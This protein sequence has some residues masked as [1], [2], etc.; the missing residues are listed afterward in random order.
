MNSPNITREGYLTKLGYYLPTWRQRWFVL[1]HGKLLYYTDHTRKSLKGVIHLKSSTA[2]SV[3]QT[4][5]RSYLCITS[6][7]RQFILYAKTDQD[8]IDWEVSIKKHMRPWT[9]DQQ[10]GNL[11]IGDFEILGR[12][13]REETIVE[14]PEPRPN[15]DEVMEKL[16]EAERIQNQHIEEAERVIDELH[17]GPGQ[18]IQD[19]GPIPSL[20]P[21][22]HPP[23]PSNLGVAVPVEP[24]PIEVAPVQRKELQNPSSSSQPIR[25]GNANSMPATRSQNLLSTSPGRLFVPPSVSSSPPHGHGVLTVPTVYSGL[26]LNSPL[27]AHYLQPPPIKSVHPPK[28]I[29]KRVKK[30]GP[31][32]LCPY[33]GCKKS[34][35]IPRL[36][37]HVNVRHSHSV[38][39]YPCP[40][41][42]CPG[43]RVILRKRA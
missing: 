32:V 21:V 13:L 22:P 24:R 9:A 43:W 28:P 42:P 7:K 29:K 10:R 39:Q 36:I 4:G 6:G 23:L 26:A 14:D 34:M 27:P 25:Q 3:V 40:I 31:Q 18:P 20:V 1:A 8:T 19:P 38:D 11:D 15:L 5:N 30:E 17:L 41:C 16:K 2:T 35:E 12:T 33:V 37:R